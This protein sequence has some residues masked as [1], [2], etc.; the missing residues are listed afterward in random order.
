MKSVV[1]NIVFQLD[2]KCLTVLNRTNLVS[3]YLYE[4]KNLWYKYWHIKFGKTLMQTLEFFFLA[5]NNEWMQSISIKTNP[6]FVLSRWSERPSRRRMKT[7][8]FTR[9]LSTTR[10]TRNAANHN[11]GTLRLY[12]VWLNNVNMPSNWNEKTILYILRLRCLI[13]QCYVENVGK[14]RVKQK[15]GFYFP[16][17]L[18]FFM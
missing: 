3:W 2:F 18:R 1:H 5:K 8:R 14:L 7:G 4:K 11:T 9:S 17:K 15:M 16:L 13:K 12:T 10:P 6:P